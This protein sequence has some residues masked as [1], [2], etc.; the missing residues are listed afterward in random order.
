VGARTLACA[1]ASVALLIQ[2]VT[3]RHNVICDLLWLYHIFR[4]YIITGAILG[5]KFLN[6]KWC[7]FVFP[8][9]FVQNFLILRRIQR[10]IVI[11]VKT[12]L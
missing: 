1:C 10:D 2:H 7:V 9:T 12:S 5:K 8:P 11:N 3:R 6:T 4:H